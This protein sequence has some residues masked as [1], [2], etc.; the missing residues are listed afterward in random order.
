MWQTGVYE[1]GSVQ[2]C[3]LADAYGSM[4]LKGTSSLKSAP[5]PL[6]AT[7]PSFLQPPF[8]SLNCCETFT[9]PAGLHL[10]H[11]LI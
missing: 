10:E 9:C 2:K 11:I 7:T 5:T 8:F 6:M 4:T 3:Q 1:T